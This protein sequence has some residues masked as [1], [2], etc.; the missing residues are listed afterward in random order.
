MKSMRLKKAFSISY[1][2][3]PGLIVQKELTMIVR[4]NLNE[5]SDLVEITAAQW[6]ES[7]GRKAFLELLEGEYT[8]GNFRM[9]PVSVS[10]FEKHRVGCA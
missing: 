3:R 10:E 4:I 5:H 8:L 9:F 7:F 2:P 1:P 6:L